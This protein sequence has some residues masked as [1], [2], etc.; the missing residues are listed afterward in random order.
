M[1][2]AKIIKEGLLDS[3]GRNNR[4][5]P[6]K[7]CEI[8]GLLFR[9][10]DSK[11]RTC[12]RACGYKVRKC[13]PHNKGKGNGWLNKKG[14]RE[15]RVNKVIVKEHRHLMELHLKRKLFKNEDVHHIDGIKHNNDL[16][17]LQ[18]I[19]HSDH[20]IITSSN[21]VYK[22]GYKLNLTDE[23]RKRRSEHLKNV[24]KQAIQKATS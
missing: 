16:S 12:S 22:T 21:R 6:D 23:E 15:I 4:K 13:N 11:K 20:S 7:K 9:P 19:S 1:P 17:N 18:L 5:I 8:C 2:K 10:K 14:Y 3:W 24:R